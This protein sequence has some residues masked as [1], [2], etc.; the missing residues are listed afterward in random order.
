MACRPPSEPHGEGGDKPGPWSGDDFA[1]C[2]SVKI[3]HGFATSIIE[4][5]TNKKPDQGPSCNGSVPGSGGVYSGS[6]GSAGSP[7]AAAIIR[8]QVFTSPTAA[9]SSSARKSTRMKSL[10]RN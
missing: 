9:M 2:D 5:F 8:S 4:N 1:E 6:L 10:M 7:R 3:S